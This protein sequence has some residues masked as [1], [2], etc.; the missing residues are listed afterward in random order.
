MFSVSVNFDSRDT[1]T[2]FLMML[3][4]LKELDK[5]IIRDPLTLTRSRPVSIP[6]Q[7][8]LTSSPLHYEAS[9]LFKLPLSYMKHVMDDWL[10]SVKGMA[11]LFL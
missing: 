6:S 3:K 5:S 11:H 7:L 9:R 8:L 1:Q 2:L 10:M 4:G